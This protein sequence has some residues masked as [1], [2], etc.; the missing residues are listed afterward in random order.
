MLQAITQSVQ[1]SEDCWAF[2]FYTQYCTISSVHN[3]ARILSPRD[4]P[5]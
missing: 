2:Y 3:D 4:D 5:E 1:Y